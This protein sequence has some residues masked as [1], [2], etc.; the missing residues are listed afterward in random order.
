MR[1]LLL[2]IIRKD[3]NQ[4]YEG[5]D[6]LIAE[7]ELLRGT[8]EYNELVRDVID[9]AAQYIDNHYGSW[10]VVRKSLR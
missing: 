9:R 4:A 6:S 5:L 3:L 7:R 2:E 1:F 8:P 10:F